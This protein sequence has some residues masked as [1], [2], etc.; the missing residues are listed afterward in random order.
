VSPDCITRARRTYP[1]LRFEVLDAFDV[2]AAL[3]LG[4]P[5]TKIYADLSGFS[6]YRALLDVIS[7]LSMYATVFRPQA[8]VVKSGALKHFAAHCVAWGTGTGAEASRRYPDAARQGVEVR[9]VGGGGVDGEGA[10]GD[11]P[12]EGPVP[13]LGAHRGVRVA[14]VARP[15]F[16]ARRVAPE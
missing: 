7:L 12:G 15:P 10:P 14:A 9:D 6:G 5:F 11:A 3:D 2:R 13:H 8:I 16:E 1:A 4:R